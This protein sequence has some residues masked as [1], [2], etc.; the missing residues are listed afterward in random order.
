VIF[1]GDPTCP[2][3]IKTCY[4]CAVVPG[5]TQNE[6]DNISEDDCL[7]ALTNHVTIWS[8]EYV[9]STGYCRQSN[10]EDIEIEYKAGSVIHRK[11]CDTSGK[12]TYYESS[13]NT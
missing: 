4:N 13:Q 6:Y 11:T 9:Y 5:C 3:N 10:C 1:G 8:V 7:L 2:S 12:Y